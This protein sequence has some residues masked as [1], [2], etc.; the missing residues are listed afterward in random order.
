[1]M[2]LNVFYETLILADGVLNAPTTESIPWMGAVQIRIFNYKGLP[3]YLPL[4]Y[5]RKLYTE[6]LI[7]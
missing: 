5:Y 1:M 4:E 6:G 3:G 7:F 2:L